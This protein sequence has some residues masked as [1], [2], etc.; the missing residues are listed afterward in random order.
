M[1]CKCHVCVSIETNRAPSRCED[2]QECQTETCY[3]EY[4]GVGSHLGAGE[5]RENRGG[6]ASG[7]TISLERRG[8]ANISP[9]W[10]L[11]LV[12]RRSF[13]L[14]WLEPNFYTSVGGADGGGR[15]F[16]YPDI[17]LDSPCRPQIGWVGYAVGYDGRFQRNGQLPLMQRL[18]DPGVNVCKNIDLDGAAREERPCFGARLSMSWSTGS[19][20][21]PITWRLFPCFGVYIP[22]HIGRGLSP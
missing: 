10:E 6:T 7:P 15:A 17:P 11:I 19:L 18:R 3:G 20:D 13:E 14:A 21:R 9:S 2:L 22:R 5:R 12:F 8:G 1:T 16:R 4:R